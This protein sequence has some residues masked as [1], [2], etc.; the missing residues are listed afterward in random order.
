MSFQVKK[1]FPPATTCRS[2]LPP[3]TRVRTR[4]VRTSKA[5]SERWPR[6]CE[7]IATVLPSVQASASADRSQLSLTH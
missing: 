4:P 1:S 6:F 3:K 2:T 7:R 5:K